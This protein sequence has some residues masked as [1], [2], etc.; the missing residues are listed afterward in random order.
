VSRR[1][2]EE[3]QDH[4]RGERT[5]SRRG[6]R[7]PRQSAHRYE[8]GRRITRVA[9][10][11]SAS[12][13]GEVRGRSGTSLGR[14]IGPK[15]RNWSCRRP[16]TAL[17]PRSETSVPGSRS[18]GLYAPQHPAISI[19]PLHHSTKATPTNESTHGFLNHD[20][21]A[22]VLTP[23]RGRAVTRY[24]FG[25]TV[26]VGLDSAPRNRVLDEDGFH[27]LGPEL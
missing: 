6:R 17:V 22:T 3:S 1:C 14:P 11:R 25:R 9:R 4:D 12:E 19:A 20:L 16:A 23:A 2:H 7:A 24:R 10:G 27:G 21:H 8:R 18:S 13:R 26:T 5:L 15:H